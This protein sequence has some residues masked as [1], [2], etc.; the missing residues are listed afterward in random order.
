VKAIIL[1]GG[2]GTRISE[3]SSTKPKPLIE[4]GHRPILWHIMSIYSHHG[5]NDFVICLGKNGHLIKEY[6]ANYILS[7]SDVHFDMKTNKVE[8]LNPKVEPWSVT[9]VDTGEQ[10]M[11]GGRLKRVSQYIGD[12]TFCMTYGDGVGDVDIPMSIET[13]MKN[14]ALCTLTAVQ[15]PGRFGAF[16]LSANNPMVSHFHEKPL[17]DGAWING[18]FFV[19][20]PEVFDYID[21]DDT[22]WENEPM[23]R[24]AN[25]GK[26]CAFIHEGFWQN[27]DTLRDKMLLEKLWLGG[28]AP[29]AIWNPNF[30]K[31]KSEDRSPLSLVI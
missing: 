24:L 23:Q 12:E 1:A 4:I 15:P 5:I 30:A 6:F 11:T 18:G 10:S 25:E 17:G 9:L 29:W 14:K 26:L 21:G 31:L 7:R 20:E 13:H 27:M 2:F 3:E 8:F 19:M 28:D 22:T 16:L